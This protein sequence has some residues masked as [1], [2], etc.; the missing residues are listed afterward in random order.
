MLCL[1]VRMCWGGYLHPRVSALA[2]RRSWTRSAKKVAPGGGHAGRSEAPRGLPWRRWRRREGGGGWG[3]LGAA[4]VH[5]RGRCSGPLA[6]RYTCPDSLI[7]GLHLPD[8]AVQAPAG[9]QEG[10]PVPVAAEQLCFW[11]DRHGT[12]DENHWVGVGVAIRASKRRDV[13]GCR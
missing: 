13:H 6:Q 5:C 8:E 9:E 1:C 12:S 2:S 7:H 11:V 10:R 3:M 4:G